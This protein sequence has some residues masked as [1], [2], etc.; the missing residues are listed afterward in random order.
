MLHSL[1]AYSPSPSSRAQPEL[2]G[3]LAS[4][5]RAD[6]THVS[7]RYGLDAQ[8]QRVRDSDLAREHD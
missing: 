1:T 6:P 2:P 3:T 5:A 8:G 4:I 7:E